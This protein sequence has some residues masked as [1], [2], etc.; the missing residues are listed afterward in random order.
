MTAIDGPLTAHD[1]AQAVNSLTNST[2][3]TGTA[4]AL[5]LVSILG[6]GGVVKSPTGTRYVYWQLLL[7]RA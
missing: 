4:C 3:I 7:S 1:V 6:A 2:V 5:R